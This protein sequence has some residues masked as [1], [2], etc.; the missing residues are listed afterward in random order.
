ML[1]KTEIKIVEFQI[2][3]TTKQQTVSLKNYCFEKIEHKVKYGLEIPAKF[4]KAAKGDRVARGE[5]ENPSMMRSKT[6]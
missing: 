4:S 5:Y 1:N 6:D 2:H 3:K